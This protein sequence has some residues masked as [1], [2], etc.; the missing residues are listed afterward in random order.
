MDEKERLKSLQEELL[1]KSKKHDI[2]LTNQWVKSFPDEPGVYAIFENDTLLWV[3]ETGNIH[4][5]MNDL[6]KTV[7]H[8]FRRI[9][10]NKR[11]GEVATSK[12]KFS[13]EVEKKINDYFRENL[14]VS[15]LVVSLGRL[16]LEEHII[17]KYRDTGIY[18]IKRKRL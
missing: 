3:G 18:N 13:D 5:R 10:G 7:N 6:R 17:E 4:K 15:F 16:E 1:E 14:K 11:Y 9:F 8:S 2:E 12:K